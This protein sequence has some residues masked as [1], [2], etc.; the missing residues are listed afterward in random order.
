M[1]YRVACECGDSVSVTETAAG[2][3][4]PCR[5]GRTVVVPSLR[6][7]RR[8]AGEPEESLPPELVVETLLLAGKLPEEDHCVLCG[9]PTQGTAFC[10]T[11]CERAVVKPVRASGESQFHTILIFGLLGWLISRFSIRGYKESGKDRIYTLPLRVCGFCQE[12]LISPG[13]IKEAL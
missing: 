12:G 8:Q 2:A 10:R 4:V 11:E 5:C 6:E 9:S 3:K 13:E 1:E 7:L